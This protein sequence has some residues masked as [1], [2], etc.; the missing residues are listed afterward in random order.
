MKGIDVSKWQGTIDWARVKQSGI[1]F[2]IIKAGGSDCGVYTDARFEANYAGAKA[3][4]IPIGAYFFVGSGCISDEDGA[5]D[6]ERFV[7]ILSGKTFE[8]PVYMDVEA[9]DPKY[10]STITDAVVAFCRVVR[11]AGFVPGVY[12]SDISGFKDRMDVSR[13]TNYSLWVARYGSDP[14]I[15]PDYDI[16]Q[17][18]DSGR[19]SGIDGNVDTDIAKESI[20]IINSVPISEEETTVE[21]HAIS[22]EDVLNVARGEL[23]YHEKASNSQLDDPNANSGSGNWTKY[24]RDLANAGYYNGNKNGFPYCDVGTDWCFWIACGKNRQKAEYLECQTGDCGAGCSFSADYYKAAGRFGTTPSIGAQIF[25][26]TYGEYEHTGLVESFDES[27]VY[28]IEFNTSDMVA[29]CSY[30]RNSNRIIGYGYPR[31]GEVEAKEIV[32]VIP[33]ESVVIKKPKKTTCEAFE[34]ELGCNGSAVKTLQCILMQKGYDLPEYADDGDFG[35]ETQAAVIK[36]QTD[37]NLD[38]DGVVGSKTWSKLLS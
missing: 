27:M 30:S 25:F 31:Y 24:A 11:Q 10:R 17:T 33:N 36:Y 5:T 4:G 19:I 1:E 12:G 28:T 35:E 22:P 2:A 21:E 16:W 6:G 9:P 14:K 7:R 15:V 38:P 3:V 37:S 34:L 29:R 13:L 32:P 8:L 20:L 18:S 23:G 26:G